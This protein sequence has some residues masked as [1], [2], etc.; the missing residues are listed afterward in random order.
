MGRLLSTII[1]VALLLGLGALA[2]LATPHG[3]AAM[4]AGSLAAAPVAAAPDAPAVGNPR[5]NSIAL[6]LNVTGLGITDAQKLANYIA[7]GNATIEGS[8]VLRVMKWDAA[9]TP[10]RWLEYYP[11]DPSAG[12][13]VFAVATGDALMVLLSSAQSSTVLSLVGDVPP[14]NP[15]PGAVNYTLS[16]SAW[17]FIMIPLDQYSLYGSPSAPVG[18]AASLATDIGGVTRVMKWDATATPPRWIEYYPSD[19]SAGDDDYNVFSGYP[20]MI[21][22]N[23]SA[24]TQWP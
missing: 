18:T 11:P 19:P 7:T 13:P 6:P 24:P 21:R 9:S 16:N 2:V 20:Y 22:T 23:A 12:D 15:D 1:A 4:T 5:W 10:Q 8:S 14:A 17:N 3:S